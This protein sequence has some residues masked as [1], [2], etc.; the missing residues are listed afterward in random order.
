[1][2]LFLSNIAADLVQW[3]PDGTKYMIATNNK[4][5][6]Y[7][8]EVSHSIR[9]YLINENSCLN[10]MCKY[11]SMFKIFIFIL[12]LQSREECSV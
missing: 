1:M 5:D 9:T 3:S 2:D 4:L 7:S 6:I 12:D 11:I 8:V 10:Y